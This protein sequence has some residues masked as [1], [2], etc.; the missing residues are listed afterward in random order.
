MSPWE[1]KYDDL[2]PRY[3]GTVCQWDM[4]LFPSI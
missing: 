2:M 4:R 3:T 1:K